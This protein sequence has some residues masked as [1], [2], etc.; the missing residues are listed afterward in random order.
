MNLEYFRALAGGVSEGMDMWTQ[1]SASRDP[2]WGE[3]CPLPVRDRQMPWG[4][5]AGVTG[6]QGDSSAVTMEV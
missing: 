1:T 2:P 6:K 3:P 4:Q 5:T